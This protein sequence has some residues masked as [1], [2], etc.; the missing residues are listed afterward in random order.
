MATLR[1]G[2]IADALGGELALGSVPPAGGA[3]HE[4]AAYSIDSR[5]VKRGDLFFALVGPQ[6]DGHRFVGAAF[7]G[8]AAAAIVGRDAGP[9]PDAPALI[10]V[11]DTTRALQDLGPTSGGCGR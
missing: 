2:A 8:E 6:H 11:E 10:R 1:L 7:A 5:S 3:E 9:F 4:V